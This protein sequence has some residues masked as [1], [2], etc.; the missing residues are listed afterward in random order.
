MT[1]K[2]RPDKVNIADYISDVGIFNP[3]ASPFPI[4]L[5]SR[6]VLG[7]V[8]VT[9]PSDGG[10]TRVDDDRKRHKDR[11][12]D[13]IK[14]KLPDIIGKGKIFTGN[15]KFK[16]PVKGGYEPK[17]RY[18]RDPKGGGGGG[19]GQKASQDKGELTIELTKE[20]L[21]QML[22]DEME[23]PDMLRKQMAKTKVKAHKFR[24]VQKVG[25]K[26][27]FRRKDSAVERIR[28]SIGLRNANREQF[29][30]LFHDADGNVLAK[31]L[32]PST[33]DIPF[34]RRDFRFERV[35]EVLDEDSKAV[36]FFVLDRSVSMDGVPL[37]LAK[38]YF[39]LNLMFLRSKYKEVHVV[40]IAHDAGAHRILEEEK[41]FGVG[42]DG[43]TDPAPAWQMVHDI[44]QAEFPLSAWN[45][46][47]F[48]AS[49]GITY[50]GS[51]GVPRKWYTKFLEIG[52]AFLGYLETVN[53]G[54]FS[55]V[56]NDIGKDLQALDEK[57]KKHVGM[58]RVSDMKDLPKAFKVILVKD[59]VQ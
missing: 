44:A 41:F 4:S 9:R 18:G 45:R 11:I 22:F 36:V 19:K 14:T 53:P 55:Q 48:Q 7:D 58:A 26:P 29:P 23:L 59:K 21:I 6:N 2:K 25:P 13:Q 35:E 32:I 52:F 39:Y 12:R 46:Y 51:S 49:D 24:G 38:A 30:H 5:T 17:I 16:V 37:L 54:S 10:G 40:M 42:V 33:T 34:K 43:G 3:E 20:E 50:G 47:M 1:E 56:W 57:S 31:P 28:R 27:F 15:G 8:V